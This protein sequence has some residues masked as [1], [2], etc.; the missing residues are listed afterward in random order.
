[1]R[2]RLTKSDLLL[3]GFWVGWRRWLLWSLCV[4]VILFLGLMHRETDAE[5]AF[6]SLTLLPV[7]VLAWI[8][9]KWHGLAVALLAAVIW[10]GADLSSS[11]RFS[12]P[13][14]PWINAVLRIM[15]YGLIVVLANQVRTQ[16]QKEH[17]LAIHDTLTGLLNRRAFMATGTAEAK[18]AQ[19][20]NSHLAVLFVDLD[21]FKVLNDTRGHRAG[22]AALQATAQAL[23][24]ATRG[25][26]FVGRLGGDEFALVF[27][28]I[29]FD[30]ALT[31]A[32]KVYDAINAALGEFAPVKASIGIAWF[33][34]AQRPFPAMLDAA[35]ALM[36]SAKAAANNGVVSMRFQS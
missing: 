27:P 14:I 25:S 1:M 8:G 11:Q 9:G 18:R 22:D 35:D 23:L 19:R 3:P 20:Y 16:F 21:N 12:T 30:P 36:Y 10:T 24:G 32:G 17:E 28:E 5:F 34:V 15:T 6:V 33:E 26:D 4:S 7:L 13:W 29:G 2:F 31:A